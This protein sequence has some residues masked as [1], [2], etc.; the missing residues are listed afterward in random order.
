MTPSLITDV[1][2]PP[3]APLAARF[4]A[5]DALHGAQRQLAEHVEWHTALAEYVGTMVAEMLDWE[6]RCLVAERE[7][8]ALAVELAA[9]RARVA[10]IFET[11][12][13]NTTGSAQ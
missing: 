13:T 4:R 1:G 7:R 6:R 9:E 10:F 2:M 11:D 8:D 12:D 5:M 3:P